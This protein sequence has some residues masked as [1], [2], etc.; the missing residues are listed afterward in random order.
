MEKETHSRGNL[1]SQPVLPD[2]A[3]YWTLGKFIKPLATIKLPKSPT[4]IRN[5]C[6]GVK[7][8]HFSSE[9]IFGQLL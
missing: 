4:F 1:F 7:I 9:N 5:F 2:L 6:K 8:D 3:I